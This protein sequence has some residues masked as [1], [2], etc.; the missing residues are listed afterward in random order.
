MGSETHTAPGGASTFARLAVGPLA[1]LLVSLI[2]AFGLDTASSQV[3]LAVV[4]RLFAPLYPDDA[5][6]QVLVVEITDQDLPLSPDSPPGGWPAKFDDYA[7]LIEVIGGQEGQRPRA[8]FFD[9]FLDRAPTI[10]DPVDHLCEVIANLEQQGVPLFFASLIESRQRGLPR[11]LAACPNP[12]RTASADWTGSA[13]NMTFLGVPG[14]GVTD[15]PV[16]AQAL[17]Q[18]AAT[19]TVSLAMERAIA[20]HPEMTIMWGSAPPVSNPDCADYDTETLAGRLGR[21][22]EL[23]AKS[24]VLDRGARETVQAQQ[25]C[26]YHARLSPGNVLSDN[27]RIRSFLQRQYFTDRYVLVGASI[28]GIPDDIR[29]PVHGTLPGVYLHAMALDNLLVWQ[30]RFVRPA[31]DLQLP[32]VDDWAVSLDTLFEAGVLALIAWQMFVATR[33][34]DQSRGLAASIFLRVRMTLS[35]IFILA[36]TVGLTFV[37]MRWTPYNWGGV[38]VAGLAMIWP[39][40]YQLEDKS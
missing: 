32:L 9:I 3:S 6:D 22:A 4:Q 2:D 30:D 21:S 31:P 38:F 37:V 13:E 7:T 29:S 26:A 11:S 24:I 10:D 40:S 16:A 25:P 27:S 18:A 8:V 33:P 28:S 12:V 14:E 36:A 15:E 1:L 35:L 17:F 34:A 19:E 20:A 5:Q 23:V 39:W